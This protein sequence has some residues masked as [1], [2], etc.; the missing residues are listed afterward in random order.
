MK[1]SKKWK[2]ASIIFMV[3]A[4]IVFIG[5]AITV[6][7]TIWEVLRIIIALLFIAFIVSMIG[8]SIN[9]KNENKK[10]PTVAV[11]FI[12]ILIAVFVM[13]VITTMIDNSREKKKNSYSSLL[14]NYYTI[15]MAV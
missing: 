15:K 14:E 6:E 10:L 4:I 13:V 7:G 3:L 12:G 9:Y 2:K 8:Y 1:N 5:M 11:I